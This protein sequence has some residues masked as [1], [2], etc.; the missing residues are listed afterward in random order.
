MD[1]PNIVLAIIPLQLV[2]C[3]ITS[4]DIWWSTRGFKGGK[5]WEERRGGTSLEKRRLH[6]PKG[7]LIPFEIGSVMPGID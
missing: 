3:Q 4:S 2:M 7:T 5:G 1:I 6:R